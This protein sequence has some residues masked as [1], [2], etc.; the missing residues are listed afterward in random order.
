M[1]SDI[2]LPRR[3]ADFLEHALTQVDGLGAVDVI[4]GETDTLVWT[5][6]RERG[7]RFD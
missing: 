1:E 5:P 7:Y 6:R 4:S 2:E 3:A